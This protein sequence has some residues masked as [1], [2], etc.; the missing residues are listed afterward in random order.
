M[1]V[2][3][4][5]LSS[6]PIPHAFAREPREI[7]VNLEARETAWQIAPDRTVAA[8]GYE[9]TVPGPTIVANAGDTLLAHL[10]NNLPEPTMIH[11]HGLRLPAAMDGTQLVQRLVQP[12]ESFDYRFELPDAGTFWYHSHANETV[13]IERGLY[14]A[15]VVLGP[16]EPVFDA[17]RLLVLDDVK[18]D[19]HGNIAKTALF[20]RHSGREGNLLVINSSPRDQRKTS[21][22]R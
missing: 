8:W 20:D 11:W 13:Q 9:G 22:D 3:P 12:G 16:D 6:S 5:H 19:R 15:I 2:P 21:P 17:D 1:T 10:V 4:L 14:G 18:L 7:H